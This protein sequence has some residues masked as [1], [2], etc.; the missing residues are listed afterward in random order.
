MIHTFIPNKNILPAI[1]HESLR[2]M[3]VQKSSLPEC[4]A[5]HIGFKWIYIMGTEQVYT[6]FAQDSMTLT[7]LK[8]QNVTLDFLSPL[9]PFV[10]QNP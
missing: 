3:K 6:L 7:R 1:G 8:Q 2:K 9:H 4:H 10:K 5:L